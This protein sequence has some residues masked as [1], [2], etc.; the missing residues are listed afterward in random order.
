M[1]NNIAAGMVQSRIDMRAYVDPQASIG[2]ACTI[3]AGVYVSAGVVLGDEA[4]VGPNVAFVEMSL[5]GGGVPTLVES[6]VTIG[7]N[8]TIYAGISIGTAALI[9]PGS[10][11]TRSVPPGAIVEGNPAS[12]VGYV[13]AVR[14]D[15]SH[16]SKVRPSPAPSV[17]STGVRG[18]TFHTFPLIPDMRGSL[19]VCEFDRQVPF[20]PK[21]SFMVFDVPNREIRGEHAHRRCHQFLICVRGNCAVMADDGRSRIEVQLD[22]PNL[23]LYLPPMTWGVQYKYSPDALL[24][25]YASDYYDPADYIRSYPDFLALVSETGNQNCGSHHG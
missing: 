13:N 3:A 25:V 9:R 22:A 18:V 10:V 8:A 16:A 21:R 20:V 4:R 11:V 5:E 7:A 14:D 1:T 24:L 2:R 6:S 15:E 23:G 12:I 17:R 19:T